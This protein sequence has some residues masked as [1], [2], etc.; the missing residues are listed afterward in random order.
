M[1]RP[2]PAALARLFDKEKRGR[3]QEEPEEAAREAGLPD[4]LAKHLGKL[5]PQQRK[6]LS[7]T[8]DKLGDAGLK[9][10]VDGVSVNFF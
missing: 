10:D 2:D 8:W 7:E 9:H 5:N 1:A 6:T 3:F 4:E